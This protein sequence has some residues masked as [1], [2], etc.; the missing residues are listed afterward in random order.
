MKKPPATTQKSFTAIFQAH[1]AELLFIQHAYTAYLLLSSQGRYLE[2]IW[3]LMTQ[4]TP[5]NPKS[6]EKFIESISLQKLR[7]RK[8]GEGRVAAWTGGRVG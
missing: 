1:R 3:W 2:R 8:D 4:L 5:G 6:L 7:I